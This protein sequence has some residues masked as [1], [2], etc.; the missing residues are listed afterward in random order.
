MG[1]VAGGMLAS[2]VSAAGG[3]GMIG[4]GS[5][6]SVAL[7][8]QEAEHPRKAGLRFGFGLLAWALAREP[9]LLDAA[10]TAEPVLISISFGD[11]WS[12]TGRSRDAGVVAATQ[13]SDVETAQ[14]AADAGVDV[15]V[16]RG[17]EGG[18]HGE[19]KV[20]TLPL[21][22]GVLGAVS[23]PILPLAGS[24][25]SVAS[26][27]CWPQVPPARGWARHSPAARSRWHRSPPARSFCNLW[28]PAP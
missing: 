14:R 17:G 12:W 10:L 5:A 21:L 23:V 16:A 2:A 26:L 9:G 8:Q 27:L 18:G 19:P 15:L 13:V 4:I 1:G 25:R 22:E 3:L 6:G 20:G 11:D 28:R 7:L 24:P